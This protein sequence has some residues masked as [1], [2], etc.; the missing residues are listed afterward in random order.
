M[1][2]TFAL[3]RRRLRLIAVFTATLGSAPL[4]AWSSETQS[5]LTVVEDHGGISALPYY[6]ALNLLPDASASLPMSAPSAVPHA[7][8]DADMLPVHSAKL[9][10]GD[11]ASRVIQAPGLHAMFIVGDDPRSR[12]WLQH[13]A[14]ELR[15][16]HASGLV[17]NVDTRAALDAL[18][19]RVPDLML[20]PTPADDLAQRLDLHHYPALITATGIEQ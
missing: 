14:G 13:R 15:D 19:R 4:S 17:V 3:Q 8:T 20:S 1:L 18:R 16:L 6:R 10:P 12:A 9:T 5:T 7:A 2:R 11:V